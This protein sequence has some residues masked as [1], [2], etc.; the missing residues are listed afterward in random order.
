MV[1]KVRI[2]RRSLSWDFGSW[3][4]KHNRPYSCPVWADNDA[5]TQAYLLAKGIIRAYAATRK[6]C[7]M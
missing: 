4:G 2:W 5:Y 7:S 1:S 6:Q 3:A